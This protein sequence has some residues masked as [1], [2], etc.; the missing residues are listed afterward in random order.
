MAITAPDAFSVVIRDPAGNVVDAGTNGYEVLSND[1]RRFQAL[2]PSGNLPT[3]TW[4]VEVSGDGK[5][6]IDLY[7]S[8]TLHLAYP[9]RHTLPTG[10]AVP[11]RA[12]LINEAGDPSIVDTA[13]FSLVSMDGRQELPIDLFDDGQHGDGAA[14]DG[15]YGGP[16]LRDKQGCWMLM[17]RGTLTDGSSFTRMYPAPIRFRGFALDDPA[18]LSAIPGTL[19]TVNFSLVNESDAN[20]GQTTTFDLEAFSDQGWALTDNVP[21]S[22]TLQPGERV[23]IPVSV[24]VPS[25]ASVGTTDN[26]MLVAAPANDIGLSTS[27]TAELDVVN[28]MELYLP[29]IVRP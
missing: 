13:N 3:G 10:R 26:V 8:S 28:S 2:Y 12:A 20:G 6:W 23:N 19:R 11:F 7:G 21:S 17:V 22:I 29:I 5:F 1:F 14:G 18:S 24:Q 25:G 16:V 15:L 4:K 27:A 9:G